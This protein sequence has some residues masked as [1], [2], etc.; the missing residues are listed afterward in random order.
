MGA[1]AVVSVFMCL[2][3]VGLV[4]DFL[5]ALVL[6][7]PYLPRLR[8]A[9]LRIPLPL[10][11]DLKTIDE[12]YKREVASGVTISPDD[13]GHAMVNVVFKRQRGNSFR[14]I[15]LEQDHSRTWYVS[16][17]DNPREGYADIEIQ[18]SRYV[19]RQFLDTPIE[20]QLLKTGGIILASG[21]FLQLLANLGEPSGLVSPFRIHWLC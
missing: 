20:W 2:G 5:G 15:T 13:P 14:N 19:L 6:I 7:S 9:V 10:F 21:F 8:Y 3:N 16:V 11:S 1:V 18:G 4:L 17:T 12:D